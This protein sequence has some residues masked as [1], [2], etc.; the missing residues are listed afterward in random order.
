MSL[1]FRI[2]GRV[3]ERESGSGISGLMVRAYDKDLLFDDLL[4]SATTGADGRFELFYSESDFR[5][6]FERRP[7]IYLSLYERPGKFLLH[8]KDAIRWNAGKDETFELVVDRAQLDPRAAS[9]RLG[10]SLGLPAGA[11]K[12]EKRGGFV[13]PKIRG[14]ATGGRPGAPA[15]PLQMRYAVLPHGATVRRVEVTPGEPLRIE[16]DG[17]P[18]PA[19]APFPDTGIDP[20]TFQPLEPLPAMTPPDPRYYEG[21]AHYPENLAELVRVE[22]M[23][24]VEVAVVEVRPV[25]FDAATNSYL[26]YRDLGFHVEFE[27]R[28]TPS[29]GGLPPMGEYQAEDL[30]AALGS[31]VVVVSPEIDWPLTVMEETPHLIITDNFRWPDRTIFA[32][33]SSRPPTLS[34][35]GVAVAGDLVAE[36]QRL[37]DWRTQ[38]GMRSMVVTISDIVA[39]RYGEFTRGGFAR[40]LQEIIR[41]FLKFAAG[42]WGVRYLVL[43][44]DTEIVPIRKFAGTGLLL[45]DSYGV[46]ST[47]S[48]PPEEGRY[49]IV[50]D[51][52]VKILPAF[53]PAAYIEPLCTYKGGVVVPF[54]KD[55]SATEL[56]WYFS[57]PPA[58]GSP[59]RYIIVEGP[60]NILND[61]YYWVRDWNSIPS[62]FYYSSLFGPG[63]DKPL[64]HDF[65]DAGSGLYG[66]T[67][68]DGGWFNQ[69]GKEVFLDNIDV[70]PDVWVG[71]VPASSSADVRAYVDKLMTYEG[72]ETPAG[73]P[74]D[75]SYLTQIVYA[76]DYYYRID[77]AR[78]PDAAKAPAPGTFTHAAGAGESHM[79][80]HQD[81]E[82]DVHFE[83]PTFRLIART[84]ETN[85]HIFYDPSF[86]TA[87][88]G[89]YFTTDE[90]FDTA[91]KKATRFVRVFGPE[92]DIVPDAFFWDPLQIEDAI[93]EKEELRAEMKK[94]Y[95]AFTDVQRH[96]ADYFEVGA[97]PP[98]VPLKTGTLRTAIDAGTHF[99]SLTGHGNPNGCCGVYLS[100]QGNFNN[101]GKYFIAY[102]NSCLTARVDNVDSL[103]EVSVLNPD[104]GA[105]AYVGYTRYGWIGIGDNY[106][107]F[108]WCALKQYGR[109][110]PAA[111]LRIGSDNVSS[112]WPRYAQILLGDP[113]LRVWDHVPS[114]FEVMIREDFT[115]EL[116]VDV[117]LAGN[118]LSDARVTLTGDG[119]FLTKKTGPHG[120]ATFS[121][122]PSCSGELL[123][124]V[125]TRKGRIYRKQIR[126]SLT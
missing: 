78:Q 1:E 118:A 55:A 95:P 101:A 15:V 82:L 109:V 96:Y 60:K 3:V 115:T 16:V 26:F 89:W 90:K 126:N 84:G 20:R 120:R 121:I 4:G 119:V 93:Q 72:L 28:A 99:L 67:Y 36:F 123:L 11:L 122:P 34:E 33:G 116:P 76:A 7:D 5:E 74:V 77:H 40:D 50:S 68:Y 108:F 19:H 91:S 63:Y 35:R 111:G 64:Q 113:A 65:D 79:K 70:A 94:S 105:V 97:P 98:V 114:K 54:N 21:R 25:Q 104:G 81:Q 80:L 61:D 18:L 23:G 102:A 69:G 87:S 10:T 51:N 125:T 75:T 117:S 6:L 124:T 106:E 17:V 24:P 88:V 73:D 110:G 83:A 9:G 112:A 86:G 14:F 13:V 53:L 59:L 46:V 56:G 48:N 62:D 71:R 45:H 52:V 22:S 38:Q 27:A 12:L 47:V 29:K 100:L 32:D 44:G 37:A 2:S 66:R 107:Q 103:G 42:T 43:G 8:T 31:D 85:T 57:D 49:C 58:P 41:N 39:G 92:A 30:L